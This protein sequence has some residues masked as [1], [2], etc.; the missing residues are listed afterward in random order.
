MKLRWPADAGTYLDCNGSTPVHPAVIDACLPFL[1]GHF[2]NGSAA[3]PG[4]QRVR[5]AIDAARGAAAQALGAREDELVFTSGGS[6]SNNHALLG[7][8]A[9]SGR[10]HLVVTAIEHKSVLATAA[11]LE[12]RGVAVTRIAPQGSGAVDAAEVERALRPDTGLVSVMLANNET[13]VLQPIPA[14][15]RA[16]R[17]RGIPLHVDAVAALGK[18]PID[19]GALG[20]DLLSVAGHKLYAPKG[21][22]LLWIRTGIAIEPLIH[23]CGQQ[24]GTRGGTEN[25]FACI[26][27]GRAL[28][29]L[30]RNEISDDPREHERI[31]RLRDELY[32]RLV[33]LVPGAERNGAGA[34][35]PNTVNVWFPGRPGHVLQA[36]L[37]A[38]GIAVAAGSAAT[39]ATPSHVLTA[40][41]ASPERASESL[42][43]S[44]GLATTRAS[45]DRTIEALAQILGVVPEAAR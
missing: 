8:L 11:W 20:C 12:K 13:G 3:H 4:G 25:A 34:A 21:S 6:E 28:E 42:R 44:L 43:F 40:M 26:G 24:R 10:R 5:A 19:V 22:G 18:V 36:E 1:H 31:G 9:A 45:I 41:G 37:G 15:A 30:A 16:T 17:A 27:F 39:G 7:V 29:L 23:G 35:L 38:R 2:A 14:I 32:A 33:E